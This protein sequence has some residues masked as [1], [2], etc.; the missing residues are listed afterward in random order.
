MKAQK[1]ND[2]YS[3]SEFKA[4]CLQLLTDVAGNN[5]SITVTKR[6]KALAEVVP[7]RE[8]RPKSVFGILQGSVTYHGDIVAPILEEW[9]ADEENL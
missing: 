7:F 4:K 3:I 5:R 6:G 1:I 8:R 9:D 2:S